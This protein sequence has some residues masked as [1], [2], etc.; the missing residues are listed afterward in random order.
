MRVVA[1]KEIISPETMAAFKDGSLFEEGHVNPHAEGEAQCRPF[2]KKKAMKLAELMKVYDIDSS[3]FRVHRSTGGDYYVTGYG[4]HQE[5]VMLLM[6]HLGTA[7]YSLDMEVRILVSKT[8][9]VNPIL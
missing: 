7:G 5:F 3:L 1:F 4:Q 6:I 2:F 9:K 8:P